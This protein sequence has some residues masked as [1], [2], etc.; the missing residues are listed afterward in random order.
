M[1][2]VLPPLSPFGA[3]PATRPNYSNNLTSVLID[4]G[5][6]EFKA[7]FELKK[8]G[9]TDERMDVHFEQQRNVAK[10]ASDELSR[11]WLQRMKGVLREID[12]EGGCVQRTGHFFFLDLGC[13]PGGFTS[14]VL[15]QNAKA[16]G[17]GISLE[18]EKGGHK[19]LLEQRHRARFS[20]LSADLTYFQLGPALIDDPR[21]KPLPAQI[22][23][24]SC[25]L[26]MLDGHFLHTQENVRKWDY[27]RLLISQLVMGLQA[28]KT[29]GTIVLKLSRP[30]AVRT[31]KLLYM[32]DVISDSLTTCK[33]RSMHANRGTFYAI[34]KGVRLGADAGRLPT[35][36]EGLK[37]LWSELTY[38][39]DDGCGRFLNETD[40]DFIISMEELV[41][42]YL[43]RVI[44]LGRDVW[45]IQADN[46]RRTLREKGNIYVDDVVLPSGF[47]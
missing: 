34:A 47:A 22:K 30:D 29:G 40:L 33:P 23:S 25:G 43:A 13:C 12:E 11:I 9:W 17:L 27:D 15:N 6:D 44:E 4:A 1:V 46:L 2:Y 39:G 10:H 31:A 18:V 35:I 8:R 16:R 24:R 41:D 45:M 20:L 37:R 42:S 3:S 36:A 32:L 14:Y 28:V 38:G 5:V 26:V 19:Y 21:L 7:L